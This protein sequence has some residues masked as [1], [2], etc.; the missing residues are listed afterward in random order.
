MK[1]ALYILIALMLV[2][3]CGTVKK[4]S[5]ES[6]QST[7]ITERTRE[8][9]SVSTENTH[10][11]VNQGIKDEI[12]KQVPQSNTGDRELDSLVNTKVDQ[13]LRQL[14]T[15]KSSGSNSYR[16]YFD[17]KTRELITEFEVGATRDSLVI[18]TLEQFILDQ[19]KTDYSEIFTKESKKVVAR[20]PWWIWAL[21]VW[22]FRKQILE[23]LAMIFPQLRAIGI[24]QR[25]INPFK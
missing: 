8:R 18:S 5:E 15:R 23:T 16:S 11:V 2:S 19:Q 3:S 6:L 9:D 22:F 17:E 25:I 13:I 20:I 10:V 12:R 24:L 21:A 4:Q 1:N 7:Q 14:N